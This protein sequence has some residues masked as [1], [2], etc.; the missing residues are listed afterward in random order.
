MFSRGGSRDALVHSL[1]MEPSVKKFQDSVRRE[2]PNRFLMIAPIFPLGRGGRRFPCAVRKSTFFRAWRPSKPFFL[3][4]RKGTQPQGDT[5]QVGLLFLNKNPAPFFP[6]FYFLNYFVIIRISVPPR[7]PRT[8][9]ARSWWTFFWGRFLADVGCLNGWPPS[10][11][12]P[13]SKLSGLWV[14]DSRVARFLKSLVSN[15]FPRWI[16]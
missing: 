1:P 9:H 15:V 13:I 5:R 12:I 2:P 16:S 11:P 4:P 14:P 8:R 6:T 3:P 7:G 10:R